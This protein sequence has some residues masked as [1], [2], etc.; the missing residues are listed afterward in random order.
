MLCHCRCLGLFIVQHQR[1]EIQKISSYRI[2][3]CQESSS[4]LTIDL[5]DLTFERSFDSGPIRSCKFPRVWYFLSLVLT[6]YFFSIWAWWYT[7]WWT[8]PQLDYQCVEITTTCCSSNDSSKA[9]V[10]VHNLWC[11][12]TVVKTTW[13]LLFTVFLDDF[14]VVS[15]IKSFSFCVIYY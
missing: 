12:R 6:A 5:I 10:K 1:R 7:W 9:N 14:D 11:S 4:T 3:T 13:F 2:E 15:L 8:P